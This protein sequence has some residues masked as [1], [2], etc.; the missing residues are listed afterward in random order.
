MFNSSTGIVYVNG[1]GG[2]SISS[3]GNFGITTYG[4]GNNV[5]N[6]VEGFT[7]YIGE[8]LVYNTALTT[9]QRQWIEGKLAWKWGIYDFL[10]TT[11]P[12]YD[13]NPNT[14]SAPTSLV[15]TVGDGQV[16][17]AF[18]PP[19]GTITNYRYSVNGGT[20]YTAYNPAVTSSPVTITGLTN[21]TTYSITLQAVNDVG[22]GD[23]SAILSVT[24][25]G[26]SWPAAPTLIPVVGN[27]GQSQLFWYPP[28]SLGLNLNSTTATLASYNIY[29][30]SNN[31]LSNSVSS[32]ATFNNLTLNSTY[33]YALA[34]VNSGGFSSIMATAQPVT[35][36]AYVNPFASTFTTNSGVTGSSG[37]IVRGS[38][39][40]KYVTAVSNNSL[41]SSANYGSTFTQSASGQT[42][43]D[44]AMSYDGLY[45]L[46][47]VRGGY[48]YVSVNSGASWTTVQVSGATKTW[49][50]TGV[51]GNGK[52]MVVTEVGGGT[53]WLSSNYGTTFTQVTGVTWANANGGGTTYISVSATG[54]YMLLY[55]G[56]ASSTG[57]VYYSSNY[58]AAWTQVSSLTA[59]KW[60]ACAISAT[61]QYMFVAAATSSLMARSTDYGATWATVAINGALPYDM[62][63][64]PDAQM[65]V[66][67]YYTS[68]V[69]VSIDYGVTFRQTNTTSPLTSVFTTQGGLTTYIT[70]NTLQQSYG[71][72]ASVNPNPPTSLTA[73]PASTQMVLSWTP[74]TYTGNSFSIAYYNIYNNTSTAIA[75]TT[76]AGY[77]ISSLTNGTPY[78]YY[79]NAV[80]G[81][82][83]S[84][85]VTSAVTATP[86]ASL[87]T[88][89]SEPQNL[90]TDASNNRITL[91]WSP[92]ANPGKANATTAA[93]I[94]SYKVYVNGVL[95]TTTSS[96]TIAL[97]G[98]TNSISY[99][100]NVIAVNSAGFTGPVSATVS[101]N[102]NGII[103][104]APLNFIGQKVG[105]AGNNSMG[106]M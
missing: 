22:I 49:A 30:N 104:G 19:S 13:A 66:I 78:S 70:N 54:Q 68:G 24:P 67:A 61:G 65:V 71:T 40:G 100:L 91:T 8:V 46:S 11:H 105:L 23:A 29:D 37:M 58:G 6:P 21:G 57:N 99:S 48:V 88:G 52:Y 80:N 59:S 73:T 41:Y 18:T 50:G 69:Y 25:A 90:V 101:S 12:Y 33:T 20:N 72:V 96:T 36:P 85:I 53:M 3:T 56:G 16:S 32:M 39:S 75:S 106:F 81:A 86:L 83:L 31:L 94:T 47:V 92:P 14:L 77:F 84:S 93:T 64:T 62:S 98:L 102:P 15:A 26:A 10:P 97:R 82:G 17:I 76:L 43:A 34:A 28:S 1:T 103:I 95:N 87:G 55:N 60:C 44:I 2:T 38:L 35:I 89:P 42:F 74:P 7:G 79:V 45:Q 63:C 4:I 27:Y 5:D 9:S 51:S